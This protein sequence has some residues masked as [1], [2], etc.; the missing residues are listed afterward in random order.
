MFEIGWCQAKLILSSEKG[1]VVR[2]FTG[3]VRATVTAVG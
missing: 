1:E 2:M 3:R